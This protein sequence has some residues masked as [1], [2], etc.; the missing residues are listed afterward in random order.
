MN[1]LKILTEQT[2]RLVTENGLLRKASA[3][4]RE[5]NGSL[6]EEYNELVQ[7]YNLV[8]K[9]SFTALDNWSKWFDT[10]AILLD[11]SAYDEAY[12]HYCA[13]RDATEIIEGAI[14]V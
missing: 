8:L 7:E 14:D 10:W 6:R 12:D 4:Q 3:E 1:D 13:S 9:Q 5:L 11:G 2:E